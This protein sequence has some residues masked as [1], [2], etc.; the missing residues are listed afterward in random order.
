MV[1][2]ECV[3]VELRVPTRIFARDNDCLLKKSFE[4]KDE[5]AK[6]N[7]RERCGARIKL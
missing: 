1:L 5:P 3:V 7:V 6:M 2:I 4:K